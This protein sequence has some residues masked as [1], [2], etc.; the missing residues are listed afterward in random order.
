MRFDPNPQPYR[1]DS[2]R[3][4]I[5][6]LV[7]GLVVA[8]V[9]VSIGPALRMVETEPE[10]V[11]LPTGDDDTMV[12]GPGEA[13]VNIPRPESDDDG[14]ETLPL[15]VGD[16]EDLP[17]INDPKPFRDDPSRL[18][19]A[20]STDGTSRIDEEGLAY[21]FQKIRS[22]PHWTNEGQYT[23][24]EE[25]RR[26]WRILGEDPDAIR[27]K[28]FVLEGV[29]VSD[30]RNEA[31]HEIYGLPPGNS[32]GLNR[33]YRSFF[34]GNKY[35]LV[36]VWKAPDVTFRDRDRVRFRGIFLQTYAND[37]DNKGKVE[38]WA[39]P[40]LVA[41]SFT[42][43]A[44]AESFHLSYLPYVVVGILVAFAVALV[45]VQWILGR[46][47]D[48]YLKRVRRL[49]SGLAKHAR[50]ERQKDKDSSSSLEG[51]ESF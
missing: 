48:A 19:G 9:F 41:E 14:R 35:Y 33:Y 5:T 18:D 8:G 16:L 13:R 29:L 30:E 36:A 15:P 17:P 31:P 7:F 23:S 32:S 34:F 25:E 37:I 45:L 4:I 21:L 28:E 26:L 6:L 49:R 50:R 47:E 2:R 43:V 51:E 40:V 44:V 42:P 10:K 11:L 22:D 3:R 46:G 12:V 24:R 38:T 1:A 39:V 20:R 27:G